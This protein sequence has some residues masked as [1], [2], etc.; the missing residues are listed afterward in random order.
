MR[1]TYDTRY[2]IAYIRFQEKKDEAGNES[3][4]GGKS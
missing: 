4:I 3:V 2:N 1:F